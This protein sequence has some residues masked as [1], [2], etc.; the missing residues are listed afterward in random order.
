[1]HGIE[2]PTAAVKQLHDLDRQS[3]LSQSAPVLREAFSH[4]AVLC[5]EACRFNMCFW[6]TPNH[7]RLAGNL[8][9]QKLHVFVFPRNACSL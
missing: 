8:T 9:P 2:R 5:G 1:M 4:R 7:G 6:V 3:L